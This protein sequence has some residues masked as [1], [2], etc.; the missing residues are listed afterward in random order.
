MV[1]YDYLN[2]YAKGDNWRSHRNRRP[3]SLGGD[4]FKMPVGTPIYAHFSGIFKRK[5]FNGTGG[6]TGVIENKNGSME[7]M[8]LSEFVAEHNEI[9]EIGQLI[10]YSG[11][12]KG[13]SGSGSSTGPHLH[14]HGIKNG[15]RVPY[16]NLLVEIPMPITINGSEMNRFKQVHRFENGKIVRMLYSFDNGLCHVW[17]EGGATIANRYAREYKTGSSMEVTASM[18]NEIKRACEALVKGV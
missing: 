15:L 9:V 3:P 12:A 1:K 14:I 7:Y 18:F 11:G 8:H 10:A 2:K 4:D 16:T 17:I 13:A 6:N 5:P